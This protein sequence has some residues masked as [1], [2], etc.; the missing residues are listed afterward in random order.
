LQGRP[1]HLEFQWS[2]LQS[3]PRGCARFLCIT[4]EAREKAM[5]IWW[6]DRAGRWSE[7]RSVRWQPDSARPAQH[8]TLPLDR[9]PHWDPSGVPRIRLIFREVGPLAVEVPRLLR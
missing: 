5:E 4:S 6:P 1:S 8:W 3:D 7:T 9:L 2:D